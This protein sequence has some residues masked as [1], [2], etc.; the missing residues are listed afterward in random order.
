M[1]S[2]RVVVVGAGVSGLATATFLDDVTCTVVEAGDVPGGNVRT[3]YFEGRVID[4]AANGWLDSEPA[5]TRLLERLELDAHVM[6]ASTR[7]ATRWIYADRKMQAVPLSPMAMLRTRLIPWWA[8]LRVLL[9]PLIPRSKKGIEET[10]HDF[11]SRRLGRWFVDRMVGPMVAGIYAARPHQLSLAAAFPKMATMEKQYRS[12]FLAM[13]AKRRGGAPTGHLQTLP[14]GAGQLTTAMADRLGETLVCNNPV[15]GLSKTKDGW[16]VHCKNGDID[17][18]AV[19]LACPAPVQAKLVRGLDSS[20]ANALDEIPYAPVTVVVTAWPAGAYDRSPHGFGVLVADGEDLGILGTLFTS[21][22][23][24]SQSKEGEFL[25][26]TM[27][28][29]AVDP[30]AANLPHQA[31]LNRVFAAHERLLGAQRAEPTLVRVY[32][33]PRGIPQYTLGHPTRVATVKNAETRFNGLYFVGNH[34]EGIGVKD[35]AATAERTAQN[36]RNFLEI[37]E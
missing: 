33:H 20:L 15:E 1:D 27:V 21:E 34:L 29:G 22:A 9:E 14:R 3:D 31:L 25:L 5:M 13:L 26:R 32:R 36:V 24:P 2:P 17:A 30:E 10:V 23:Y 11:V 8:K 4:R 18:R 12:L 37:G 19:V 35:C 6:P 7:S 16:R 28:G